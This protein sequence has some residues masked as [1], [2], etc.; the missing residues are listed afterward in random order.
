MA[1]AM[2]TMSRRKGASLANPENAS[3]SS[4]LADTTGATTEGDGG[5]TA[6]IDSAPHLSAGDDRR[7]DQQQQEDVVC[8]AVADSERRAAKQ[9]LETERQENERLSAAMAAQDAENARLSAVIAAQVAEIARL[10]TTM[11]PIVTCVSTSQVETGGGGD[12]AVVNDSI[13]STNDLLIADDNTVFE[14]EGV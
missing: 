14:D 4:T 13:H 8:E 11:V 5:D 10:S 9:E 2:K 3:T 12:T 6:V 7:M 1:I